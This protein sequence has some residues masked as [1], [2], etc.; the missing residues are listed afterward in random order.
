MK[1]TPA[2][3]HAYLDITIGDEAIGRVVI[4]L[5]DDL[6]P[7]SSQRF[8]KLCEGVEVGQERIG[9]KNTVFHRVLKNFV[10]QGGDLE[11]GRFRGSASYPGILGEHTTAELVGEHSKE[12]DHEI[13]EALRSLLPIVPGE[14]LIDPL[15][16]PFM[17]CMANDG[18][19][20]ANLSQF[21]IT[22]Y[23]QPHLSGK[24]SVFGRVVQ[25]KSVVREV[26]RVMTDKKNMPIKE[27]MV[28]IKDCGPWDES[29]PVPIWNASY[30]QR[31]GDIYEEYPDDDEH[32]DKESSES[33]YEAA[34]KI[35]ESG[36]LLFKAGDKKQA[37]LKYKKCLRYVM[38][39]VPDDEQEPQWY[40]K[41]IDLKKKLYLNLSLV[42][43]QLEHYHKT[44]DYATYILEMS[45]LAVSDKTKALFRRGSAYQHLRKFKI[46]LS[47]LKDAH[48]LLPGD[49]AI[50]KELHRCEE[51]IEKQKKAEKGK[52][53]KFFG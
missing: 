29:M 8:V 1:I 46:A 28:L 19:K 13:S 35:K 9:Y 26:E 21:F 6:A 31:G 33:V 51:L 18:N 12:L 10:I 41:Y 5:F 11:G 30:D 20:N 37:L 24:H 27:E 2:R 17:L 45:D 53:A 25:G 43:F 40:A 38:E 44:V 16:I 23:P 32:I 7:L 52:Y 42:H 39:Y 34:S 36:T 3:S 49:A 48:D 22:T 50:S 4:E 47:D 15:S 14:N